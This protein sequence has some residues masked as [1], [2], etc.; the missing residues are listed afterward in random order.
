MDERPKIVDEKSR[1]GDWE[2]DTI[3]SAGKNA[4]IATFVDR[5]QNYCWQR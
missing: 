3:E 1:A 5:K 4:S 2:G